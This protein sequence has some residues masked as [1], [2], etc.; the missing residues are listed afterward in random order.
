M[1]RELM[2]VLLLSFITFGIAL[3]SFIVLAQ[4]DGSNDNSGSSSDSDSGTGLDSDDEDGDSDDDKDSR[5][6]SNSGPGNKE[7]REKI[8]KEIRL[9][10]G[11]RVKVKREVRIKDGKLEVRIEKKITDANGIETKVELRVEREGNET[12]KLVIK[13]ENSTKEL[14]VETELEIDDDVNDSDSDLEVT[15]SRGEK[16]RIRVLPDTASEVALER[17]E[18]RNLTKIELK[19]VLHKNIPRIVYE[20]ETNKN[21]KF[22]G[23][24]KL[25][26]K[27]DAQ[28]DPETGE[29][30]GVNVPWWA[31]LVSEEDSSTEQADET[32][33][34]I[35]IDLTEENGS[36]ESG[37]A[38]LVEKDG[39][40]T[41]TIGTIGFTEGVSQPAH[42]HL[43][44]C[45]NVGAVVYPL[46]NVLNGESI[47]VLDVT[48]EQLESELP[49]G[50]NIHKSAEEPSVYTS[51]GDIKF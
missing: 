7:I 45:P 31:F 34:Q 38:A 20:I 11:S 15:D 12:K 2:L 3:N 40:T 48:L 24:F 22:L 43:G 29:I 41:V 32:A 17:L 5:L 39:Q 19:E 10:D 36:G 18:A 49:L 47:T 4:E 42:I 44:A 30:L 25:K 8:E 21:G 13:R 50:I 33:N 26:I 28:I 23:V 27:A 16:T 14:E 51:C 1:K 46:T 35:N 9:E 37:T 6:S